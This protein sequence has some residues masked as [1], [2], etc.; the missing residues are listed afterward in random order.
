MQECADLAAMQGGL[1]LQAGATVFLGIV[2]YYQGDLEE[3]ERLGLQAAEW[4]ERTADRYIQV[5][6]LRGLTE[7]RML[8]GD[9]EGAQ[10]LLEDALPIATEIGGWVLV[11][12]HRFLAEVASRSGRAEE[13]RRWADTARA[14]VPEEALDARATAALAAALAAT[15]EGD[16]KQ[17][18]ASFEESLR[19]FEKQEI[20]QELGSARIAYARALIGFGDSVAAS[21]QLSLAREIFGSMGARGMM[22]AI[23]RELAAAAAN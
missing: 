16:E 22:V 21:K 4:L 8:R 19:L 20:A 13:A 7:I 1:G 12:I 14:S 18:R 6:N 3:A 15:A 23:D 5:Q 9:L 17:A 11:T 2:K 10:A